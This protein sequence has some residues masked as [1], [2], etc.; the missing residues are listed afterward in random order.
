MKKFVTLS[1]FAAI[2]LLAA[3][4]D[5]GA[6]GFMHSGTFTGPR[7]GVSTYGGSGG[8]ANGTCSSSGSFTGPRGYTASRQGST[9]CANGSCTSTGSGTGFYG[10]GWSRSGTVSGY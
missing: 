10:R 9:S 4:G 5:A 7:G 6:R 1:S 3:V 2:L 8:C